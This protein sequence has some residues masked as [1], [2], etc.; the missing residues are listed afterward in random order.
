M[1]TVRCMSLIIIINKW[2]CILTGILICEMVAGR[3]PFEGES[4]MQIYEKILNSQPRLPSFFSKPISDL[5]LKLLRVEQGK[6]LGNA[7]DGI[8]AIVSH[9]WYGNFNWKK[10]ETEQMTA[11]YVPKMK[12]AD[13]MSNFD[14]YDDEPVPRGAPCN[15]TPN[16]D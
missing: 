11:P 14:E 1:G 9:K 16:L 7:R 8:S 4:S 13:D 2:C 15:W 6:R 12:A 3:T 10:L 5:I